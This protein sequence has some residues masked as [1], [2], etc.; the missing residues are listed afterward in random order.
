MI[1][2]SDLLTGTHVFLDIGTWDGAA[3]VAAAKAGARQIDSYDPSQDRM[4]AA[5]IAAATLLATQPHRATITFYHG[6]HREALHALAEKHRRTPLLIRLDLRLYAE[7]G[8]SQLHEDL[9]IVRH[10]FALA[11]C[12]PLLLVTHLDAL[13]DFA[14]RPAPFKG[15]GA[16]RHDYKL[17][18]L[19]EENALLVLP[20]WWR[21][22]ED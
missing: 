10:R 13:P 2:Y 4:A 7:L 9:G 21:G 11:L 6:E 8:L 14:A 16:D 5:R 18:P 1:D 22:R 17:L 19:S 20:R 15:A 12:P 3:V